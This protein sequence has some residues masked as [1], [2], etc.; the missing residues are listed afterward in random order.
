MHTVHIDGE[1]PRNVDGTPS[2]GI[3]A[4]GYRRVIDKLFSA[5]WAFLGKTD[6]ASPPVSVHGA[7]PATHLFRSNHV[8]AKRDSYNIVGLTTYSVLCPRRRTLSS[9]CRPRLNAK[10]ITV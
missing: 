1:R 4:M 3:G 6:P 7:A 2:S 10:L 8:K 5:S 9:A